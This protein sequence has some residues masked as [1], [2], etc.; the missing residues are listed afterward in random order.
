MTETAEEFIA[1]LRQFMVRWKADAVRLR[2]VGD[3]ELA[4]QVESWIADTERVIEKHE[5]SVNA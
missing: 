5:A 3:A 1:G 4:S 2:A